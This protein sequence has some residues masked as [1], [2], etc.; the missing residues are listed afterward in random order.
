MGVFR[1]P[2][3]KELPEEVSRLREEV[4]RVIHTMNLSIDRLNKDIRDTR[5]SVV[6]RGGDRMDGAL[7]APAVYVG[8]APSGNEV[9]RSENA[10]M[11]PTVISGSPAN[12]G[13]TELYLVGK[14]GGVLVVKRVLIGAA[15][16]GGTGFRVLRV[17]N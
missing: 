5:D 2:V 4:E 8:S 1:V 7:S 12:E 13:E 6:K 14:I 9:L 17:A 3:P 11:G 16:S 15:D 10:R